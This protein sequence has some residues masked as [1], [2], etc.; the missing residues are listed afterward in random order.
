M[1]EGRRTILH[2]A[3]VTLVIRN[4]LKTNMTALT[5]RNRE[6]TGTG[7]G[8]DDRQVLATIVY[9]E[10]MFGIRFVAVAASQAVTEVRTNGFP[11]VVSY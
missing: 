8:M 10:K 2:N 1:D 7:I 5:P 3:D 9:A 6:I 4:A 11:G